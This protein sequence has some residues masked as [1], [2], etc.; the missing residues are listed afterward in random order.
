MARKCQQTTAM[1]V[2]LIAVTQLHADVQLSGPTS[3]ASEIDGQKHPVEPFYRL[4]FPRDLFP[5]LYAWK[6]ELAE[7]GLKFNF[8]YLAL[9]QWANSDI[10]EGNTAGGFAR[11][12]GTWS[13][14][15]NGQLTFKVENRHSFT[16]VAP[17]DFGFDNGALS[18]TGTLFSD[19]GTMLTNLFWSQTSAD[20]RMGIRAGLMDVTDYIDSYGLLSPYSAFQNAVFST[21]ATINA[22]SQG[23][24]LAGAARV[25]SGGLIIASIA[26]QNAD[27]TS[28]NFDVFSDGELFTSLDLAYAPDYEKIFYSNIHLTVWHSDAASDGSREEDYGA[29][30]SASWYVA[31][32]WLPF[33]RIGRSR[34]RA[35]LYETLV[36]TGIGYYRPNG[37]LAGIGLNWVEA[38]DIPG[39]QYT[40]ELFYRFS[41]S[42]GLEITPSVQLVR[43]PL[44]DPTQDGFGVFSLR[45][46]AIF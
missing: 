38:R 10:G 4:D 3:V 9:A 24:G 35:A 46:R 27:P 39:D 21:N 15:K 16:D 12:Y 32:V 6:D 28:P 40:A 11:L 22:P 29:A 17:Q 1:L 45:F 37:D 13:P 18:I 20:N 23:M 34:G 33:I 2:G 43:N 44:L 26:D 41:L 42:P 25:G 36:S 8:E 31:D 30:I 14:T 7:S 5:G 19:A